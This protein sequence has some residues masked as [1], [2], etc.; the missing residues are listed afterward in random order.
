MGQHGGF[1]FGMDVDILFTGWPSGHGYFHFFMALAM[2]FI[3][4]MFAQIYAMTPMTTPKMVPKS[5]IQHAALH[6]FRTFISFLVLLCVITFN[7]GV[8]MTTLVGHVA[9][10]VALNLYIHY[11]YPAPVAALPPPANDEKA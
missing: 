1:W 9:G 3:L 8:L 10:Y 7:L 2:V 5:L 4:S 6:C 11:H